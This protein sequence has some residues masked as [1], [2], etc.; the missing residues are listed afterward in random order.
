M[1][2]WKLKSY[3]L[4]EK[5]LRIWIWKLKQFRSTSVSWALI[6]PVLQ[7]N[8]TSPQQPRASNKAMNVFRDLP[9]VENRPQLRSS[10]GNTT[11]ALREVKV[12]LC[13]QSHPPQQQA[14]QYSSQQPVHWCETEFIHLAAPAA[15]G[16]QTVQAPFLAEGIYCWAHW[17]SELALEDTYNVEC[18]F[19]C[20]FFSVETLV[21]LLS[22]SA[23]S[24]LDSAVNL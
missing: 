13:Q 14:D 22:S 7:Y 21:S 4:G 18:F 10:A 15:A 3:I 24:I 16:P 2:A 17:V 12:Q 6:N 1:S 9:W 19:F 8:K 23:V 20:V 11:G 5:I